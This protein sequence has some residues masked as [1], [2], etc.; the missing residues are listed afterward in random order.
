M[1]AFLW[2]SGFWG[3]ANNLHEYPGFF[4]H[5][6]HFLQFPD[7]CK[8]WC[9]SGGRLLARTESTEPHFCPD[10][11]CVCR[12]ALLWWCLLC[13][14]CQSK[15]GHI[16]Q[17][18]ATKRI[19][20]WGFHS[21]RMLFFLAGF[22][23][24]CFISLDFELCFLLAHRFMKDLGNPCGHQSASLSTLSIFAVFFT[25]PWGDSSSAEVKIL[26]RNTS[27]VQKWYFSLWNS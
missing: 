25:Y 20:F 26:S 18:T 22:L 7:M 21:K 1:E 14:K 11:G 12:R 8:G 15:Q 16:S 17:Q 19:F 23:T 13:P 5:D 3:A 2:R 9:W 10:K 27:A 4:I 24:R 6:E